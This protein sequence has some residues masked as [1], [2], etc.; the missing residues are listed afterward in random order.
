[1]SRKYV[2]CWMMLTIMLIL[3][4]A[5]VSPTR[6]QESEPTPE[7]DAN[8]VACHEHQYYLYDS[9]KWFCLCKAP[10]HCVYCHGGRTDSRM[11]D[12]AHE[13]IV[14]YPTRHEA[15]RCQG[16]HGKEYLERVVEF[17]TVAGVSSTPI[18]IITAT[19]SEVPVAGLIESPPS[20]GLFSPIHTDPWKSAALIGLGILIVG[21]AV[22]GYR[23]WK[24]DCRIGK[25]APQ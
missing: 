11:K 2:S 16:C 8:C 4:F 12:I 19:P 13:G 22:L 21:F 17:A 1:M 6:A 5:L 10:M 9:G 24:E 15:E 14:L 18:A 20:S 25:Q 7:N 23:C 3:S